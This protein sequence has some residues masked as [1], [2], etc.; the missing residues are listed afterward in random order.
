MRRGS[1]WIIVS[2]V[3]A[4]VACWWGPLRWLIYDTG[5]D[6]PGADAVAISVWLGWVWIGTFIAALYFAKW[7]RS[8]YWL[9][10]PSPCIGRPCGFSLATLAIY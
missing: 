7:R 4:A 5:N 10:L 6:I 9:P 8:G 2:V 1:W 3:V